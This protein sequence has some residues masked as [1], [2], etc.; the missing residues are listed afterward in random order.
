MPAT[1]RRAEY[2]H[3]IQQLGIIKNAEQ[4][5]SLSHLIFGDVISVSVISNHSL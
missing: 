3:G 4:Q 1:L 5:K 2:F